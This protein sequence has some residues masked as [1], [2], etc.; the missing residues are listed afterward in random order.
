MRKISVHE[1]LEDLDKLLDIAIILAKIL[2]S[3]NIKQKEKKEE[4]K[5]FLK[6]VEEEIEA[7]FYDLYNTDPKSLLEQVR[8]SN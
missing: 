3:R 4:F 6:R 7:I 1:K 5:E 2:A 8:R